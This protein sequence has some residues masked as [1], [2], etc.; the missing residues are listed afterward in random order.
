MQLMK[1]SNDDAYS[2]WTLRFISEGKYIHGCSYSALNTIRFKG[3]KF[4]ATEIIQNY[5]EHTQKYDF[6]FNCFT[7]SKA[8]VKYGFQKRSKGG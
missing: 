1:T 3:E 2:S 5:K 7:K 8:W 6:I 4:L